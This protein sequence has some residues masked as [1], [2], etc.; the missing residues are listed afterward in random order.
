MEPFSARV[1][2]AET[3]TKGNIAWVV[4]SG[5]THFIVNYKRLFDNM[6]ATKDFCNIGRSK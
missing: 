2:K 6:I 5:A 1:V 3:S 4:D